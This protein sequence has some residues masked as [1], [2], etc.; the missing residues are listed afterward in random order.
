VI[1]RVMIFGAGSTGRGHVGELAY[2]AGWHLI[3]V[4]RDSRLIQTLKDAGRY[5]VHLHGP[6]GV[7]DVTVDRYRAYHVSEIAALVEHA[8]DI[9]LILT[10]VFSHNL[11]ETAPPVA[12]I[13]A[14]RKAS[15]VAS[16]LNIVC[17]ENMQHSG[18]VLRSMVMPLLSPEVAA[19]AGER[20]GFPDCMVSRVVPLA[21]DNPLDMIAEDY[22]EWTV[23]AAGFIGPPVPLPGMELVT[24]QEARLARKFFLHNGGHAVCGYW[25]VHRGHTY[26]HE[27]IA[28]PVVME[29]VSGAIEELA[30]VV[31]RHYG[32]ALDEA[33]DY[34]YALKARGAVAAL[35]DLILRVV[36]DPL[37]KL[38]R[39]ER[40]V[41]PAELAIRY[42]LP[43]RELARAMAAALHYHDADD[44]QSVEMRER[45][46]T[47][48]PQGAIPSILGLAAGD[49]LV[50]L[51]V[52]EY[53]AWRCPAQ[54]PNK[55]SG[56][57]RDHR[58]ELPR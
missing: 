39:E 37:R 27:A 20:V 36:R 57:T 49:P 19:Y 38:S 29:H 56:P 16:P 47:Q 25:G 50:A 48:R 24:N 33:R 17:C 55:R 23:D 6:G 26:I 12:N 11:H 41:A 8:L 35:R 45:L 28:D 10:A 58:E 53:L 22:N 31:S 4:D 44:P 42:G 9:P 40:F 34:G 46:E 32:F 1:R 52:E 21:V 5:T 3:L 2:E 51:V 13:I 7:R 54:T 30:Q 43:C 18:G 14:T 15:G